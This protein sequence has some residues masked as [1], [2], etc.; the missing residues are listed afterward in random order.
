MNQFDLEQAIMECW[1]VT[2][3][4]EIVLQSEA[5][6]NTTQNML[7]GLIPLYN[8]KFEKLFKAF[9]QSLKSS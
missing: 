6:E 3:D 2:D 5:D 8:Y 1:R 9:E 7:I 4:L